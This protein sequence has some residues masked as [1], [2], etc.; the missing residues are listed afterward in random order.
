MSRIAS[1]P[2][3]TCALTL[4]DDDIFSGPP[5]PPHCQRSGIR[6]PIHHPAADGLSLSGSKRPITSVT[7]TTP[8]SRSKKAGAKRTKYN[9]ANDDCDDRK[10]NQGRK[11]IPKEANSPTMIVSN[12]TITPLAIASMDTFEVGTVRSLNATPIQVTTLPN[13]SRLP[14]TRTVLQTQ[15]PSSQSRTANAEIN[16]AKRKQE[17]SDRRKKSKQKV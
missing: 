16:K 7:T 5:G 4:E 12:T 10:G 2:C 13:S 6:K 9:V 17:S 14:E 15:P 1:H 8:Q 3:Y 11:G